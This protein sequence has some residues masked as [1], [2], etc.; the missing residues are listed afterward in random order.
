MCELQLLTM[1]TTLGA[2]VRVTVCSVIVK[3]RLDAF[4]T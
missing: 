4:S 2:K 3:Q 1:D